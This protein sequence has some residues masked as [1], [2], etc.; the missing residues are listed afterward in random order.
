MV[1]LFAMVMSGCTII[2]SNGSK[3]GKKSSSSEV[4]TSAPTS[5][6]TSTGTYVDP[7][8]DPDAPGTADN[9]I[10]K[11]TM[12]YTKDFF[13][14][15]GDELDFSVTFTGGGGEDE[16]GIKW[17]S[18]NSNVLKVETQTKT[19]QCVLYALREGEA[20]LVAKSTY[21]PSLTD[22]VNI[23]VIDNSHYTYCWQKNS[24]GYSKN[25][26]KL[27]NGDD[28]NTLTDGTVTLGAEGHTLDWD[29]HFDTPTKNV[30]GGQALTFGSTD[31]PY[32]NVE[33]RTTNTRKIRSI[34]VLCS[35][36]AAHIDDGSQ[37]GTSADEGSSR[38]TITI[39]DYKYVDDVATPK[40]S[41]KD[42]PLDTV[43]G[44][45]FNDGSLSGDIV[46]HF[47]PT[48]K[49][50]DTKVNAGAIYMKSIII[51]YYRGDLQSISL[52]EESVHPTQFFVG[53][54]FSTDGIIV[55]AFFSESPTTKVVV[56][57]Y[58]VFTIDEQYIDAH[59]EFTTMVNALSVD[60][61]YSFNK[62]S[63]DKQTE[64]CSY[65]INVANTLKAVRI[66]GTLTK[67]EYLVYD[68]MDYSGMTVGLYVEG[69]DSA[70]QT[71]NLG[72]YETVEFLRVFD[73]S[74]MHKVA[75]KTIQ[76]G[77]TISIK[78]KLT[79]LNGSY[80]F[81][82]DTIIVK[83]V[84]SIDV[85]YKDGTIPYAEN[86]IENAQMDYSEFNA[87]IHYDNDSEETIAFPELKSHKY[88]DPS[89]NKAKERFNYTS[90]SPLV[91]SESMETEGF[92]VVVGSTLNSVSG[93]LH[94]DANQAS[95]KSITA[96]EIKLE[97]L[98][99]T[100]YIEYD[101]MDYTGVNL[102]ITYDTSEK[103]T[104]TFAEAKSA[105]IYKSELSGSTYKAVAMPLFEI[106][107]PDEALKAMETDGFDITITHSLKSTVTSTFSVP[108]SSIT[109][110]GYVAKTYTRM[111]SFSEF[112]ASG[113]YI[114][115]S[116]DPDNTST[117][118]VWNGAL[119]KDN[120]WNTPAKGGNYIDYSHGSTIGK[121][122]TI[123]KSAV[124]KAAFRITKNDDG[125][126]TVT[127]LSTVDLAKPLNLS[128]NSGDASF[129]AQTSSNTAKQ[130]LLNIYDENGNVQLGYN[131]GT[132]QK[133]IF[134]NKASNSDRFG[135]FNKGTN[136]MPIQIYKIS[137]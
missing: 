134:Y 129:T 96:I 24:S 99:T 97:S 126:L 90:F 84:A 26:N 61:A 40:Y 38:I 58:A 92:D 7:E 111:E 4:T 63:S 103:E 119:D 106:T 71:F 100:S 83:E 5:T 135:S 14:Q 117:C 101:S 72:D 51:E 59:D 2:S 68:A 120:I 64:H 6:P 69:E 73:I 66:E 136:T 42:Q 56:T 37:Y 20:V 36:S 3:G 116:I 82:K 122:L 124:E 108:A 44:G 11:I 46:I 114:I 80:T 132:Y 89:D 130:H 28:G 48:Y 131:G 32:G 1:P 13:M 19:S 45:I 102:E 25:D 78:H 125:T 43:T 39:G 9:H 12:K 105:V 16:K 128:I 75:I 94:I 70:L 87:V 57:A 98:T 65:S 35:S 113:D 52:D 137:A 49:D 54:P 91:V 41:S 53:S 18:S 47:S 23:T 62:T 104:I 34:S 88:V 123:N 21:N 121:T 76:N 85:V 31:Y 30:G 60:I 127:L 74:A 112:D 95:V 133:Y 115:T 118:K 17:A 67:S 50:M 10:T 107:A 93:T 33:F 81:E 15:V 22:S 110:A 79:N 8:G 27:F 77:F 109:V 29:F 55:N 86:L